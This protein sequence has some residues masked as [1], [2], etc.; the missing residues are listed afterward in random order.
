MVDLVWFGFNDRSPFSSFNSSH[1]SFDSS[2][3]LSAL[4]TASF[5]TLSVFPLNR[6]HLHILSPFFIP[7]LYLAMLCCVVLRVFFSQRRY[8]HHHHPSSIIQYVRIPIK[9]SV[10][11]F[12]SFFSFLFFSFATFLASELYIVVRCLSL[13]FYIEVLIS[14]SAVR[15]DEQVDGW[16]GRWENVR[17]K[18]GSAQAQARIRKLEGAEADRDKGG[19]RDC[20]GCRMG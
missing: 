9:A 20:D 19:R 14:V 1:S 4:Y 16:T 15:C 3:P 5:F 8:H 13:V 17:V 7:C 2:S 18:D 10:C 11:W 6:C 12:R